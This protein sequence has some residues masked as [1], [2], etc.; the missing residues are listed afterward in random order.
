MSPVE[1]F[2][3]LL[4]SLP[5]VIAAI[6]VLIVFLLKKYN[7]YVIG[8]LTNGTLNPKKNLVNH[9]L[10]SLINKTTNVS[11]NHVSFEND[12]IKTK[13]FKD[14]IRVQLTVIKENTLALI[15]N[16]DINKINRVDFEHELKDLLTDI[17]VEYNKKAKDKF[18]EKGLTN[19]QAVTILSMFDK[20]HMD[21]LSAVYSR[22]DNI[23]SPIYKTNYLK[24]LLFLEILCMMVELSITDGVKTFNDMNGYFKNLEYK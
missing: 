5:P 16:I 7:H 2:N 20:W 4:K 17:I 13:I 23:T 11:L 1:A 10:F 18:L 12:R 15:E 22:V 8:Y 21:T 9:E 19:E 3:I 24:L 6:L 14:F